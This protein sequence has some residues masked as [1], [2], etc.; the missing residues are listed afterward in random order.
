[1]G[2]GIDIRRLAALQEVALSAENDLYLV[3]LLLYV[4]AYLCYTVPE[5][6]EVIIADSTSDV[7]SRLRVNLHVPEF[8][9]IYASSEG[10]LVLALMI[11][12]GECAC[13][14][15]YAPGTE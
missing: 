8:C 1:M 15:Y 6:D 9:I 10:N 12:I 5:Q 14:S 4:G 11:T 13:L 2:S 7:L 3:F